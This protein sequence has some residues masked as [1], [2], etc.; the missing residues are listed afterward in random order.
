MKH[1]GLGT[2]DSTSIDMYWCCIVPY[3]QVA[4]GMEFSSFI[5]FF[6]SRVCV[7]DLQAQGELA[8]KHGVQPTKLHHYKKMGEPAPQKITHK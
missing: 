2:V 8:V 3:V 5:T 4:G 1:P 7:V 6:H